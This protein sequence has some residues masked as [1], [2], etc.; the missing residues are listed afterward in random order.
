[1]L[2]VCHGTSEIMLP[3]SG[4]YAAFSSHRIVMRRYTALKMYLAVM[5]SHHAT[6]RRKMVN[7]KQWRRHEVLTGGGGRILVRQTHLPPN[8]DFSSDFGHFVSKILKNIKKLLVHLKDSVKIVISGGMSPFYFLTG[9][10][11]P[12]SP[13]PR[14]RRPWLQKHVNRL[15]KT[16]RRPLSSSIVTTPSD[17]KILSDSKCAMLYL[18]HPNVVARCPA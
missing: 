17:E 2:P 15:T 12:P 9:G 4:N 11:R 18:S 6:L 10:T 16:L 14:C 1:M 3:Q 5:Q 13:P 7:C 8:S